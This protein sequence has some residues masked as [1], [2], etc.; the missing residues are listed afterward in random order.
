MSEETL[1]TTAAAINDLPRGMELIGYGP[2]FKERIC[3]LLE[4]I[5]I[6]N[7]FSRQ[8]IELL[9]CYVHAYEAPAKTVVIRE[10]RRS[11][12]MCLLA[13]GKLTV[14]KE[15]EGQEVKRLAVIRPG[16]T[17]GEMSLIDELPP[18]ATAVSAGDCT[19]LLLTRQSFA[20]MEHE[21]PRLGLRLMHKLAQLIS[22]RLRQTSGVLI[23]YLG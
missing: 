1:T 17:V 19:L 20:R 21:H 12:Y 13:E 18:S 10:G 23:D 5:Q 3:D 11:S 15:A 6:L 2:S 9:A 8:E 14:Y 7:D 4:S 22:H 16:K